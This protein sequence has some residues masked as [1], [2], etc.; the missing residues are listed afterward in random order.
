M[1]R[2][3]IPTPPVTGTAHS[4]LYSFNNL[5]T[6]HETIEKR[7]AA[8]GK[9]KLPFQKAPWGAHYGQVVG[10]FGSAVDV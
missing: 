6:A 8:G 7:L 4:L 9:E 5:D 3:T 1:R 2:T 10:P